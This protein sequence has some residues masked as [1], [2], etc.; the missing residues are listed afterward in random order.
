MS[1]QILFPEGRIVSGHPMERQPVK[2]DK[3]VQKTDSNGQPMFEQYLAVAIPKT[4]GVDW[5]QEPWGQT[6]AAEA[7]AGWPNGEH[8]APTFAWKITDGDSLVPN[9]RGKKPAEREG[10]PGC[11]VLHFSTSFGINCFHVGRY[12]PHEQ[13]QNTAEIKRGDYVK[14]Y[15]SVKA[16][17]PSPSPG[18]Y[19][20]PELVS[21]ER[22]GEA[23]MG[24]RPDA[25]AVF[26]NA[27]TPAP[28]PAHDL[29]QNPAPPPAAAAERS[30]QLPDGKV[31]T[32]SALR[33]AGYTDAHFA[34]MTPVA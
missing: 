29:V 32:E 1:T 13:I 25:Q 27:Q 10:W 12:A 3:G 6:I 7:T 21:L 18:V 5:R 4:P 26:G 19:L 30:Y 8:A 31:Y 28:A 9:K 34:T 2:D 24:D 11:W 17:A 33:G 22:A 14:V 20:N 23:I 15:A 16:N